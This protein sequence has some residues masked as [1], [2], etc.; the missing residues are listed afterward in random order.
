MWRRPGA[1][2]CDRCQ[3]PRT[4]AAGSGAEPRLTGRAGTTRSRAAR[5]GKRF[6]PR[7]IC[8]RSRGFAYR[9]E[10][11]RQ[12]FD[13]PTL[14]D[15][16]FLQRGAE[17]APAVAR[18]LVTLPGGRYYGS[19]FRIG[20]DLL[21]T[22]HHVLFGRAGMKATGV[23]AWLHYELDITGRP[24]EHQAI[25]C[26]VDTIAGDE[27]HDWAV[28]RTGVPLPAGVPVLD[29][30]VAGS[31]AADD[32][33][34]I[35]QH[36]NGGMKKIGMHHNVVRYADEDVVQCWTVTEPGSSGSP[37]FSERWELVARHHRWVQAGP[38]G[39]PEYR[40]PAT[41]ATCRKAKRPPR[42]PRQPLANHQTT[43][44][45]TIKQLP[46]PPI[47]GRSA[48]AGTLGT[49]AIP[50]RHSRSVTVRANYNI[51]ACR[52]TRPR[53]AL[54]EPVMVHLGRGR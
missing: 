26:R 3:E 49:T 19:G 8:R 21:L 33:V 12:I 53:G 5:A 7:C 22:N 6:A 27:A 42:R 51:P 37:V 11:E 34:Y 32:R 10:L 39:A 47:F 40:K 45:R 15:V 52:A 16:A 17:L 18:Q 48:C 46:G 29:L 2:A 35:I 38:P 44:D 24:R 23:E 41:S 1:G 4:G 14:L 9:G 20:E 28:I 13:Q 25:A 54:T 36:P 30:A 50:P 43:S 31:V